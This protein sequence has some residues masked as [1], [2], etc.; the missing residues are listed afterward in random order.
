[1]NYK[2]I[3][4]FDYSK[5]TIIIVKSGIFNFYRVKLQKSKNT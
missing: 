2:T 3:L 4:F 1:M 5:N